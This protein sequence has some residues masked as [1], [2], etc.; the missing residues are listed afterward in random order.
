LH[1]LGG[2]AA[3]K[4]V[5]VETHALPEHEA[6]KIPAQTHREI[7]GERLVFEQRLQCN[8]RG[9]RHQHAGEQDQSRAVVCPQIVLVDVAQPV[10][11][12]AEDAEQQRFERA[13]DGRTH[14][15]CQHEAA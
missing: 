1:H 2:N 11:D 4:L 6:V 14:R 3:G 8:Q 7:G 9:A 10:D 5:L 13:N 15:H 12:T